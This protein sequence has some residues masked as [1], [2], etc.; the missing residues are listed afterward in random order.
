M[1]PEISIAPPSIFE[2][3]P[4]AYH[5]NPIGYIRSC[6]PLPLHAEELID[7]AVTQVA[8]ERLVIADDIDSMGLSTPLPN[9]LAVMNFRWQKMSKVG[10][11]VFSMLPDVRG[12]DDKVDLGIDSLPI[13]CITSKFN[14]HARLFAEWERT[15]IPIDTTMVQQH[16]RRVSEAIEVSTIWGPPANFQV[17]N[18]SV[19]GLLTAPNG[20]IFIYSGNLKWDDPAKTGIEIVDDVLGMID[21]EQANQMYG[22]YILYVGTKYGNVLN[23]DYKTAQ[24]NTITTRQRILQIN[25]I[26]SIKV[27]DRLPKDTALLLQLTN[28]VVKMI[29]GQ[30]PTSLSWMEGPPGLQT[31]RYMVLACMIPQ[32]IETYSGG[33]GPG[34]VAGAGQSGVVI[35]TSNGVVGQ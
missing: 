9:W 20:S 26:S 27:A 5:D 29:K 35:G 33:A 24:V 7:K 13:Y 30:S 1:L 28:N 31:R 32:V 2:G 34:Q 11:A 21:A 14:L 12:E 15:G 4:P 6:A 18:L 10:N 3:V 16:T 17:N 25:E 19:P 23:Q 8:L 22:P